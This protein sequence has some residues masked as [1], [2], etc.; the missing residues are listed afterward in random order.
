MAFTQYR[1]VDSAA[2]STTQ[3]PVSLGLAKSGDSAATQCSLRTIDDLEDLRIAESTYL[4]QFLN[5]NPVKA[6]TVE[7]EATTTEPTVSSKA[8]P[9]Q[10]Q[11]VPAM[12]VTASGLNK[13]SPE[14]HPSP[15]AMDGTVPQGW[16]S[17]A[18]LVAVNA[19]PVVAVPVASVIQP[20]HLQVTVPNGCCGGCLLQ[21]T[22]PS[23]Q[24]VQVMVPQGLQA[25]N[26]FIVQLVPL[27]EP[28]PVTPSDVSPSRGHHQN[29]KGQRQH[30]DRPQKAPQKTSGNK[31]RQAVLKGSAASSKERQDEHGRHSA[32]KS[33]KKI[34]PD[35]EDRVWNAILGLE[36]Q[37]PR[38]W[39]KILP[40]S[41][42]HPWA[43]RI[44]KRYIAAKDL[45]AKNFY[46]LEQDISSEQKPPMPNPEDRTLSKREWEKAIGDYREWWRLIHYGRK[47]RQEQSCQEWQ[48][49][50]AWQKAEAEGKCRRKG[51]TQEESAAD[52]ED[53]DRAVQ[54]LGV[55]KLI[56]ILG[57][58]EQN[59]INALTKA[60]GNVELAAQILLGQ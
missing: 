55:Q 50:A 49:I 20:A 33:P 45:M 12:E 24:Q 27:S 14:F 29:H 16:I 56:E 4:N 40:D 57:I 54:I 52:T 9:A 25:G 46:K 43:E 47:L 5:A 11:P 41:E 39:M 1:S 18:V 48:A 31:V 22:A 58:G 19:V 3:A 30:Q 2:S 53:Y 15:S 13:N 37:A 35:T 51:Q 38:T 6:S 10:S 32:A 17:P 44:R 26:M 28:A 60:K 36:C 21:V 34:L 7:Q 23:G 59:A 8:A 42:E